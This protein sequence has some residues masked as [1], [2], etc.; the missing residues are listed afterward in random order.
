MIIE[1]PSF[2]KSVTSTRARKRTKT[3]AFPNSSGLESFFEKFRFCDGLAFTVG[4]TVE[5]KLRFQLKKKFF[6]GLVWTLPKVKYVNQ[7]EIFF[8]IFFPAWKLVSACLNIHKKKR[9]KKEKAVCLISVN[10]Y[11]LF[12]FW[13]E[14]CKS[15]QQ[16]FGYDQSTRVVQH[17]KGKIDTNERLG[18]F[19]NNLL[20]PL[21]ILLFWLKYLNSPQKIKDNSYTDHFFRINQEQQMSF[22]QWKCSRFKLLYGFLVKTWRNR[23]LL[24]I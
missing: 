17:S 11:I 5:I 16:S 12:A 19:M 23:L 21:S 18:F 24:T 10:F 6:Y 4:L 2:S 14:F 15:E 7:E 22:V 1:T 8:R 13:T 3:P 20:Y 9:S